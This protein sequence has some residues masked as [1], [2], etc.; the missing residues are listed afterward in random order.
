[1]PEEVENYLE[2]L[3]LKLF[4]RKHGIKKVDSGKNAIILQFEDGAVDAEKVMVH[5]MRNS[6]ILKI[7]PDGKLL[8]T[9]D[10]DS[11]EEKIL[12]IHQLLSSIFSE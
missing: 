10:A 11:L 8:I 9:S 1:M 2:I 3:G 4:C 12:V 6:T 5:V 7:K